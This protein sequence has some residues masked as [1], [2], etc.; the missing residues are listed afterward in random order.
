MSNDNN[1]SQIGRG[2]PTHL[3]VILRDGEPSL[4]TVTPFYNLADAAEFH[5]RAGAQWSESYLV[6]ILR[7]P[8]V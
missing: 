3:V 2:R 1:E 6:E 5:D 7:G 4:T 8:L